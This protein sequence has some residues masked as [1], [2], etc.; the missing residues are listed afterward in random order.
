MSTSKQEQFAS[1]FAWIGAIGGGLWSYSDTNEIG[2]AIVV[3]LIG[4]AVGY[5]VGKL[6]W[7]AIVISL[8]L[9][10][11]V[12]R[13]VFFSSVRQAVRQE[14]V[15]KPSPPVPSPTRTS[16]LPP[17]S[18]DTAPEYLGVTLKNDCS[19]KIFVAINYQD[20]N[21]DWM[22]SGWWTV[23][24]YSTTETNVRTQNTNLYFYANSS[25]GKE[26]TGKEEAESVTKKVTSEKFDSKNNTGVF[27]WD[28]NYR[29][30]EFF[31]RVSSIAKGT[32][33]QSFSCD[34]KKKSY[35]NV[36]L[37]NTCSETIYVAINYQDDSDDWITS[38]WWTVE[39]YSTTET[40]VKTQNKIM[41]LYAHSSNGKEWT[42][43]NDSESV[44]KKVT[45]E[46]FNSKNNV[47][48]YSWNETYREEEFFRKEASNASG[49]YTQS[50]SCPN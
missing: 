7:L 37:K 41:Y 13:Q 22:T 46:R 15:S 48:V 12:V 29:E 24:P 33:T 28:D 45:S 31:R 10:G 9:V 43:A 40:N 42:G 8:I 44:T 26:W 19:E 6:L 23:A 47:G 39:P 16:Q 11:F 2:V 50:F 36:N 18:I 25:E 35:V 27:S 14:I 3:A 49:P 34:E 32:F 4:G 17:T 30:E 21:D 38:G 20:E 1:F 5:F